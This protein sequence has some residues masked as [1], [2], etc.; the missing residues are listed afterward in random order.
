MARAFDNPRHIGF[1][2]KAEPGAFLVLPHQ[3]HLVAIAVLQFDRHRA[4]CGQGMK[5]AR[6]NP[7]FGSIAD[8]AEI[9][10][11]PRHQLGRAD[12]QG[13]ARRGAQFRQ[14]DGNAGLCRRKG[15]GTGE[16]SH[17]RAAFPLALMPQK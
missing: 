9:F 5:Y 10:A 2:G 11:L 4:A 6:R 7:G 12:Q 14:I 3:F 16:I 1:V 8:Y 15:F 17:D 13:E